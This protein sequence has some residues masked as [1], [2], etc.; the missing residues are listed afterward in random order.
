MSDVVIVG[1]GLAGLCCALRLQEAGVDFTV[2]EAS[3][4]VGG[5]VRSDMERGY[6]FDRGFQ[7]FTT[8][9]PEAA[10][11]LD[12]GALDLQY[13]DAGCMIYRRGEFH[14]FLDPWRHL[15][16]FFGSVFSPVGSVLDKVRVARL[17]SRVTAPDLDV[18]FSRPELSTQE[19]LV[20]EGFGLEIRESFFRPFLAG[21][22]LEPELATSSRKF[23]W[24]FRMFSKGRVAVPARGMGR[25]PEQL[26][27]RLTS[28][29]LQL[30]TRVSA[31][32]RGRVSLSDG[33]DLLCAQIVVA[34]DPATAVRLIDGLPEVRSRGVTNLY[35][36]LDDAPI[37]GPL[38]VLNGEGSGLVNHLA[39]LSEVSP[40]YAPKGRA[41][42]SV[43]VL[44]VPALDDRMLDDAVRQ[45]LIDW[46]GMRLG[47]WRLE[48]VYRIPEALP[49]QRCGS[50]SE[51]RRAARVEDWLAV[52]GDWRN[53][54]SING[55]MESGRLAAE[56]VLEKVLK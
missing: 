23:Q 41:L 15:G 18:L 20:R 14:P 24:V 32:T 55:A 13:F 31:I 52:A 8:S 35:Y 45:Q 22:F 53:L 39:F 9:Y 30:G 21:V 38:L 26:A 47:D 19:A 2:V 42:V 10:R 11:V 54:A 36:S 3:D 16:N 46:F 1:A 37:K 40:L 50:L 43:T 33:R 4:A 27:A 44:G 56:A 28:G 29:Q 34:T 7:V 51:V 12:Y 48:R 5:R 49:E 17:R 25:I 6:V